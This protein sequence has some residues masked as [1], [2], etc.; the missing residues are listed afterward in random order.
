[1][2]QVALLREGVTTVEWKNETEIDTSPIPVLEAELAALQQDYSECVDALADCQS[3]PQGTLWVVDPKYPLNEPYNNVKLG[4]IPAWQSSWGVYPTTVGDNT[5]KYYG[6]IRDLILAGADN[7]DTTLGHLEKAGERWFGG[8]LGIDG[9][10]LMKAIA[11]KESTHRAHFSYGDFQVGGVKKEGLDWG[12]WYQSFGLTQIK[13]SVWTGTWPWSIMSSWFMANMCGALI[14]MKYNGEGWN[15]SA[16]RNQI[17][18]SV[19]GWFSGDSGTTASLEG[20]Q[21]VVDVK[22]IYNSQPWL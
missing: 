20:Q 7:P 17:W 12:N 18:A 6:L 3:Q 13:R 11:W 16:T 2:G 15:P 1:M 19:G 10:R 8:I 22:A 5:P 14:R 9:P 4:S 21:Y